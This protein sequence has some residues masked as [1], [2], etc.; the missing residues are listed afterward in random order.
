MNNHKK[1][2][3]VGGGISG[4][5]AAFYTKRLLEEQQIPV[6]I[7]LIEK[8]NHVGGKIKTVQRDGFVIEKGPD[9]FL[10][11]KLPV[12]KLVQELGLEDE[13]V[14][15]NA[16]AKT[17]YIL[18]KGKLHPMP[19]GLV[20][21]IPTKFSSFV[22]TGLISPLGKARAAMDFL[23]P[24]KDDQEDE[25]LGSFIERRLG[26]EVLENITEP[27][28]SGIYSG[29]TQFLS[30]NATFPQFKQ[31]EL[32]HR[33]L[34]LGMLNG[35]KGARPASNLPEVAKRSMF[36]SFKNGLA[37]LVN[38][39]VEELHSTNII[40]GE[41]IVELNKADKGYKVKLEN[42][43]EI[44]ADAVVLAVPTTVAATL[45]PELTFANY[46]KQ[47][48]YVS[49]AN[50]A[51]AYDQKDINHPLNGSG[52]LVPRKEGRF[53]TACTW[54]S[55]KWNHT[56]PN[57]KVLLRTYVGRAN[58]EEWTALSDAELVKKVR[59][60]IMETM[61][62]SAEPEFIEISRCY[63]S[64]PQYPVGHLE[65]LRVGREE[66]QEHPGI[67]LCGAGYGGVG[68]PNCIQQGRE[69][70]EHVLQLLR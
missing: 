57:E 37:T 60:D 26:K 39:L 24:K 51:L 34:I 29:D 30:L 8:S 9:S 3:V 10:A 17:N 20:L 18:H 64:M 32:K 42:G 14:A 21:G 47:V 62:I 43:A 54:T 13:L 27:L 23:L 36:L 46:L 22:K 59:K 69:A 5:S 53:I 12:I 68:I 41:G 1:V 11:R 67:Y 2:V 31:L 6:E 38:R 70:A 35:T 33:S 49:V 63:K 45:L 15:T 40:T 61:G 56:A 48:P 28:L 4:L 19:M 16:N 44:D 66:L 25:S 7:T 55:S 65:Q 58:A 52:F 50:I